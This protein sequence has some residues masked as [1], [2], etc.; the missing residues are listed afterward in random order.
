[1]TV[2]P[3]LHLTILWLF[4]YY[5]FVQSLHLLHPV[6]QPS[7]LWLPQVWSLCL[8]ICFCFVCSFISFF[9]FL[10]CLCQLLFS[11]CWFLYCPTQDIGGNKQDPGNS[12]P[13]HSS[14]PEVLIQSVF[15]LSTFQHF[16]LFVFINNVLLYIAKETERHA[17]TV[18]C[19]EI[20][21]FFWLSFKR[22]LVF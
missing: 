4:C 7:S 22:F 17:S 10:C 19:L 5:Q 15:F 1:M 3:M 12:L 6:L 13:C 8:W 9:R 16:I 21:V 2:F 20:E 11:G 14:D 18:A